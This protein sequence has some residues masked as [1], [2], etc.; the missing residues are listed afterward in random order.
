MATAS[1]GISL[2]DLRVLT[3]RA[4]FRLTRDELESLKPMYDHFANQ[5]RR[6]YEVLLEM[7]DVAV[8]FSPNLD[9]QG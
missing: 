2:E 7:E 9:P 1:E 4:G 8:T 6:L 5:T 3:E